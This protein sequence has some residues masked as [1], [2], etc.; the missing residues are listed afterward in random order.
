MI[1]DMLEPIRCG[2]LEHQRL[3]AKG[4]D[5]SGALVA[6]YFDPQ[7]T[8]KYA[9]YARK[10]LQYLKDQGRILYFEIRMGE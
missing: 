10:Q 1:I 8:K 4:W 9:E 3:D 2:G 7:G 6:A 5:A